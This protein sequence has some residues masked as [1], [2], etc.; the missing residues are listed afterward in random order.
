LTLT[1]ALLLPAR[2]EAQEYRSSVVGTDFDFI[3]D[4]DPN[5][6]EQLEYTGL[7]LAEMP[8][9]TSSAPLRQQA[10]VFVSTFSDGT[11]IKIFIDADY[12]TEAAAREEAIR[13]TPRLG[14]LPTALREGVERLV[15]HRGGE[16]ATAFSDRGLIVIYS[17][18][19]T[20]RI[21]THDLEETIFHESVHAAWD[22]R[23]AHSDAWREAQRSDGA[24]ITRYAKDNPDG[25]DLAESALFAYTLLHHP[26]RI[27][28]PDAARL[29]VA[30]PAR[31]A[32][33]AALIPPG[34]PVIHSAQQGARPPARDARCKLDPKNLATALGISDILS[35]ALYRGLDQDEIAVHPFLATAKYECSTADELIAAAARRFGLDE[36]AVR[37]GVEEYLHCNCDHEGVV[38]AAEEPSKQPTDAR[39]AV[40]AVEEEGSVVLPGRDGSDASGHSGSGIMHLVALLLFLLLVVNMGI[41]WTLHRQ[42]RAVRAPAC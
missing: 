11:H 17:D 14:R 12:E 18:N 26:E 41:L 39:P 27:P 30:I 5:T 10:F 40:A 35:N 20:K 13:Y 15:V 31:I 4:S 7:E 1:A 42:V 33:V 36:R 16:D 32:F 25:E 3:T 24:F 37:A 34:E 21:S 19:A 29:R 8:D 38:S 28:E 23:H 22:E 6:F 2:V 9:K